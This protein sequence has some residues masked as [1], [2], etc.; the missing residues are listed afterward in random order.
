MSNKPCVSK[1][2]FFALVKSGN[3]AEVEKFIQLG[4]DLSQTTPKGKN[5]LFYAVEA[6][7]G[8]LVKLFLKQRMDVNSLDCY[9]QT[10]LICALK[11]RIP[12][13][14]P[15]LLDFRA[16]PDLSDSFGYNPLSLCI[17]NSLYDTIPLLLKHGANPNTSYRGMGTVYEQAAL[18]LDAFVVNELF[19]H[20]AELDLLGAS[21]IENLDMMSALLDKKISPDSSVDYSGRT[22]LMGASFHGRL[23]A[24]EKLI[25]HKAT[26]DQVDN[27]NQTALWYAII[28]NQIR[29]SELL[30][31][32]KANINSECMISSA[33]LNC[34]KKGF[35]N[36]IKWL[37]SRGILLTLH[38]AA[39]IGDYHSVET[40]LDGGY[41]VDDNSS[42]SSKGLWKSP[43]Y[44]AICSK[45]Y[46]TVQ[47][48]LNKG[49]NVSKESNCNYIQVA[50]A[51]S[52]DYLVDL[53]KA[54]GASE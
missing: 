44:W 15:S 48:L 45:S 35:S 3:K 37:S 49:A 41:K 23:N 26:V 24:I 18:H 33:I 8:D 1:T 12:H 50:Q 32:Y 22:P 16:D 34:V 53:L 47:I 5:A 21:L 28:N 13:V 9:G 19:E 52:C 14:I 30:L 6:G 42:N 51:E 46:E 7:H 40:L 10:P 27:R 17:L 29:A 31:S 36:A 11:K 54:Y 43:L 20:G 38:S 39:A 2:H 25:S 4:F